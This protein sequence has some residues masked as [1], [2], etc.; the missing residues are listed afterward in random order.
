[1]G[2]LSNVPVFRVEGIATGTL[3]LTG[4]NLGRVFNPDV[5]PM[6]LRGYGAKLPN[7]NLKTRPKQLLGILPLDITHPS[8][9]TIKLF[10]THRNKLE[11]LQ[12]S[13]TIWRQG[14]S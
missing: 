4:R 8:A 3:Q 13:V 10:T 9:C 6:H 1:M 14:W 2:R 12:L 11:C 5:C 7:L